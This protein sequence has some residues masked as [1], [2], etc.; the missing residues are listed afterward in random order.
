LVVISP[1]ATNCTGD[2]DCI[3]TTTSTTTT[4]TTC[5]LAV[6][7]GAYSCDSAF[8]AYF[9]S[10]ASCGDGVYM[11]TA[12]ANTILDATTYVV[13]GPRFAMSGAVFN[14][15]NIPD[16][17]WYVAV[18]DNSG[19]IG[20]SSPIVISCAT[21]TTTTTAAPTTSTTTTTTTEFSCA[22]CRTWEYNGA[23]IPPEG[24]QIT[25]Y[26]CLD[27]SSQSI[28]LSNGDPTGQFCNCNSVNNPSSL[29]GTTLT[30]ISS[31]T[32]TSTTTTTT[33]ETPP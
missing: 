13:S 3:S 10:T 12:I 17:T 30:D 31:C 21:T 5:A 16:G 19:N 24:D 27:G 29:N 18:I 14:W 4:T 33:T 25:Y 6:T 8:P 32:I 22:N 7:N 20:V 28:V 2:L 1:S 15:Q 26:S 23:T 11:Y 9:D